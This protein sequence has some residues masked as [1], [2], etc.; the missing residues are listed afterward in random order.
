[1]L[2][3]SQASTPLVIG[4]PLPAI[5]GSGSS[6]LQGRRFGLQLHQGSR[7]DALAGSQVDGRHPPMGRYSPPHW[8]PSSHATGQLQRRLQSGRYFP[9]AGR[10]NLCLIIL[11]VSL[12]TRGVAWLFAIRSLAVS[13]HY[14]A[15]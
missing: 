8:R 11:N 10:P 5:L 7:I 9:P 12:D 1:M 2:Q 6:V 3:G 15:E 4:T 13:E 14:R